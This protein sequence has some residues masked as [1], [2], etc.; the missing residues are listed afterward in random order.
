MGRHGHDHNKQPVGEFFPV[1][2]FNLIS[3]MKTQRLCFLGGVLTSTFRLHP[4]PFV[5][6]TSTINAANKHA[7]GAN[8]GC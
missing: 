5:N 8:L 1:L 2:T 7:C 3:R 4:S 6:A